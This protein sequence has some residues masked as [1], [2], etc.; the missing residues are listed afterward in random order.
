MATDH[1]IIEVN[2]I[3]D[4]WFGELKDGGLPPRAHSRM[5]WEKDPTFDEHIRKNFEADLINARDGKLR[6]WENTPEGTLA[7]I[8][9][10]DQFSRNIYRDMPEAFSRDSQALDIAAR[11]IQKGFDRVL[12]PVMR[13]FFY[14]PFMHSEDIGVQKRS[15]ELYRGLE[16]EYGSRPELVEILSSS[17]DYAEKHYAIVERF[18]RYPHRNR[19]L[20]RISTPE[21]K[22]FL[23]QPGSS[24]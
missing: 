22:E 6:G 21:E 23:K 5:W 18:G 17:R 10:L 8:I 4:F 19:I 1:G 9:L 16:K 12:L 7:L 15:V 14:M 11:G 3:L 2:R 20:G 24:F 13:I